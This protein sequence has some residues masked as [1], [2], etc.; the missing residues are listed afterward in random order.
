MARQLVLDL[1][2]RQASGREDFF[3]SA[4]NATAL[5]RLDAPE[6]WP[7]GKLALIGPEASGKS[8]LAQ[9]WADE[10]GARILTPAEL[11]GVSP[12]EITCPVAL[13]DADRVAGDAEEALFHLHNSLAERRLPLLLIGR[14]PPA[15]WKVT[16][17]DLKSRLMATDV[18]AIDAPDD[19]LLAAV[20]VKQFDD[21]GLAV[22]PRIIDWLVPRMDRSFAFAQSLATALD[23]EALSAGGKVTRPMAGRVL[24][25]L[26]SA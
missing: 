5:A 20:M 4:A 6:G 11:G 3:V 1:P 18:T 22:P 21:R 14:T 24:E 16:L 9:V 13:D 15:R 12:V 17:P 23:R 7:L 26:T 10:T 19:A 25:S 8:H 2:V